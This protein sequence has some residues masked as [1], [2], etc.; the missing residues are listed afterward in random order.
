MQHIKRNPQTVSSRR[1]VISELVSDHQVTSQQ[2]LL[3]LL[4]KRGFV[5]TQATLSRDLEALGAIKRNSENEPIPHYV[6]P[7]E[8]NTALRSDGA[9]AALVRSLHELLLVPNILRLWW[10][11]IRLREERNFL[12]VTSIEV[13]GLTRWELSLETTRFFSSHEA[14]ITQKQFA[15]TWLHWLKVGH[16]RD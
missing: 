2:D 13:G 1:S 8:T 14:K 9:Q 4:R 7:I 15:T 16:R 5:V 3:E 11:F 10:L 6:V 12:Q